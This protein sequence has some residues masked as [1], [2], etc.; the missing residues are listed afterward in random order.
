MS[1]CERHSGVVNSENTREPRRQTVDI[2]CKIGH[3]APGARLQAS[4]VEWCAA[5]LRVSPKTCEKQKCVD[6]GLAQNLT[7]NWSWSNTHAAIPTSSCWSRH[8]WQNNRRENESHI[9]RA[10]KWNCGPAT[11]SRVRENPHI[12]RGAGKTTS[13]HRATNQNAGLA[14]TQTA[15]Q[16]MTTNTPFDPPRAC[17]EPRPPAR[18]AVPCPD[19]LLC[20]ARDYADMLHRGTKQDRNTLEQ[21]RYRKTAL[22][23]TYKSW[24]PKHL[25]QTAEPEDKSSARHH[26]TRW[27]DYQIIRTRLPAHAELGAQPY[28]RQ[29]QLAQCV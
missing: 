23:A 2:E 8:D 20:C 25:Q 5:D 11:K 14:T 16:S 9:S 4:G 19:P 17:G 7:P 1:F 3:V 29:T 15:T 26:A 24:P 21:P 28:A 22:A 18:C 6:S 27:R 12:A 10:T 13:A